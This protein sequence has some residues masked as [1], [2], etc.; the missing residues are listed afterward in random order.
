LDKELASID[1]ESLGVRRPEFLIHTGLEFPDCR[2]LYF[3]LRRLPLAL[4][5]LESCLDLGD[6][7]ILSVYLRTSPGCSPSKALSSVSLGVM[8]SEGGSRCP[9]SMT[10]SEVFNLRSVS[11]EDGV[12]A[13]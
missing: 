13:G 8:T 6:S 12:V 11:G 1:E 4:F 9:G 3:R 2:A 5:T 10:E 7:C